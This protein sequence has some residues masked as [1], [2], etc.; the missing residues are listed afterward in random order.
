MTKTCNWCTDIEKRL[1]AYSGLKSFIKPFI[2]DK[3]IVEIVLALQAPS[4]ILVEVFSTISGPL[5]TGR[6]NS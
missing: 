2:G 5:S 1:E 3:R 6:G 4:L